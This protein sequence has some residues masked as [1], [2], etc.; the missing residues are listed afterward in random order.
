M[1][2]T[3]SVLLIENFRCED[4]RSSRYG[5]VPVWGISFG[6]H[7]IILVFLALLFSDSYPKGD[8]S[9]EPVYEVGIARKFQ[10]GEETFYET[11]E[12]ADSAEERE[13]SSDAAQMFTDLSESTVTGLEQVLA[14]SPDAEIP[15]LSRVM[16]GFLPREGAQQG[17][18][19]AAEGID[20][21]GKLSAGALGGV[22]RGTARFMNTS[23]QGRSFTF[24][25]D[26]SASM[27]GTPIRAAKR[28][29]MESLKELQSN[30]QFHI[31]FYN[32][33][34]FPLG[35]MKFA[36]NKN[37][38]E[39]AGL[40]TNITADGGTN[41]LDALQRALNTRVDVIFF[42]T[43]ADEPPLTASQ[44]EMIHQKASGMQINTIQFGIGP[45]SNR[46]ANFLEKLAQ[47]NGGQYQYVDVKQLK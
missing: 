12:E 28:A 29:L 17:I 36:T 23:G 34:V 14:A 8:A 11:P 42:M 7:V 24:V 22:G 27:A 6:F 13:S 31:I 9:K 20:E 40:L 19:S 45:K 38:D 46:V 35:R 37:R 21:S 4:H 1:K 26:R 10:V 3:K 44:L 41:H 47:Q 30:Q 33:R 18:F 39:V 25:L 15:D 5:W 32:D 2:T 43:D 16:E